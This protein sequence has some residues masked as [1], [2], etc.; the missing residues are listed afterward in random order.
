MIH[1]LVWFIWMVGTA[2][3]VLSWTSAVSTTVGWIGFGIAC[4]AALV[5]YLP[6]KHVPPN[7]DWAILT[8]DMIEAKDHRYDSV[9]EHLRSGRPAS[10]DGMGISLRPG[11]EFAL[12]IV[13]SVPVRE[14]DE[15]V[16]M[17]DVARAK[18]VLE[19]LMRAS[20]ELTAMSSDRT[21][22][23]SVISDYTERAIEVCRIINDS[24]DWK[25]KDRK[26]ARS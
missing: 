12:A 20:P 22:R 21:L 2:L 19:K 8:T 17:R 1:R 4:A 25:V 13:A 14:L 5:S 3:I 23:I 7:Q 10:Y 26:R 9:M 24:I 11:N 6:K 16:V 18:S 15:V